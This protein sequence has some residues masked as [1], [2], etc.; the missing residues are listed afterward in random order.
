MLKENWIWA[1]VMRY[2]IRLIQGKTTPEENE[3]MV[4]Y[5]EMI[6]KRQKKDA[7]ITLDK[8]PADPEFQDASEHQ[9]AK[10]TS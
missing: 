1:W 3:K 5:L 9:P 10:N 2:E 7:L 8:L 6:L 4:N